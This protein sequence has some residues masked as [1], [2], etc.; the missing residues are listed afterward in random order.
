LETGLVFGYRAFL[1]SM[2]KEKTFDMKS[3]K[4]ALSEWEPTP[5]DKYAEVEA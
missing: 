3:L 5:V 2:G 4:Q 1:S